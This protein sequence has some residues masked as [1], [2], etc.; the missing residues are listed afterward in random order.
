MDTIITPQNLITGDDLVIIPRR[1]YERLFNF[2]KKRKE[3]TEDDILKWSAESKM[4][5]R[6]G[7]L[8]KFSDLIKKDYPQIAEK[9]KIA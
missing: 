3:V 6:K 2:W 9:Y 4:L 5:N 8:Q 1:Q 7:K